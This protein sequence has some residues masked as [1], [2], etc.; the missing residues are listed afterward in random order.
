MS[1]GKHSRFRFACAQVDTRD[2]ESVFSDSDDNNDVGGLHQQSKKGKRDFEYI[3]SES[4]SEQLLSCFKPIRKLFNSLRSRF[5]GNNKFSPANI[6]AKTNKYKFYPADVSA[7][8]N[9]SASQKVILVSQSSLNQNQNQ[10][11]SAIKSAD[12]DSSQSASESEVKSANVSV[13]NV[14]KPKKQA[15]FASRYIT[16]DKNSLQNFKM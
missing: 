10:S 15:S 3:S 12:A 16:E 13:P 14:K 4:E 5:V 7:K 1:V 9:K 11:E 6:S 2:D 8:T